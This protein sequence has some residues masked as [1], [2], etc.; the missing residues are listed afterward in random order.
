MAQPQLSNNEILKPLKWKG[1]K[2][3]ACA[4]F[5][6]VSREAWGALQPKEDPVAIQV[7]VNMSFVHHTAGNWTCH[8]LEGCI[9]Q[10]RNIQRF[11]MFERGT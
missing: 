1:V 10:V 3:D 5:Q 7:P 2:Q 6:I 9:E 8:D 11:H 4:D